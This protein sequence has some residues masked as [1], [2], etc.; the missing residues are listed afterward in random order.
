LI[1]SLPKNSVI[2]SGGCSGPDSWAEKAAK[3][4]GLE[5][6]IFL[7]DLPPKGSPRYKFTEAYYLRNRLIAENCDILHAFVCA[8]RKGGTEYTINHAIKSGKKVIIHN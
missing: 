2:I 4:A 7:P 5:V 3:G 8:D 1:S 6:F